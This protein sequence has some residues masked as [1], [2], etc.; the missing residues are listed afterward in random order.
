MAQAATKSQKN[1]KLFERRDMKTERSFFWIWTDWL[2]DKAPFHQDTPAWRQLPSAAWRF[3]ASAHPYTT[4]HLSGC[5]RNQKPW[6]LKLSDTEEAVLQLELRKSHGNTKFFKFWKFKSSNLPGTFT[7]T[8][9]DTT[10]FLHWSV[11][12]LLW[13]RLLLLLL[14]PSQKWEPNVIN[15]MLPTL[16]GFMK[17]QTLV[18]TVFSCINV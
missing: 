4:T 17:I 11:T 5:V 2:E 18:L 16:S 13:V 9:K 14:S 1:R 15:I 3:P 8:H 12:P 10:Q 7:H 6:T